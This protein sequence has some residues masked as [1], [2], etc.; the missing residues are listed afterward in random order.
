MKKPKTWLS[1]WDMMRIVRGYAEPKYK[2]DRSACIEG[3]FVKLPLI[4]GKWKRNAQ[5]SWLGVLD[6]G[7]TDAQK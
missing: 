4:K 3:S 7:G 5:L 2:S 1:R 6:G